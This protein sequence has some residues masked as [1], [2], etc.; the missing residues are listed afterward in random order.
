MSTA[1]PDYERAAAVLVRIGLRMVNEGKVHEGTVHEDK[2]EQ[3]GSDVDGGPL[4]G[5]DRG[6]SGGGLLDRRAS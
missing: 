5:V 1:G 4:P 6:A 3:E 2:A